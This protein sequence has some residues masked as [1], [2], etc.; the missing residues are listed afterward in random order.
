VLYNYNHQTQNK[1][2][3]MF[4]SVVLGVIAI[5]VFIV[6]FWVAIGYGVYSVVTDSEP[7]KVKVEKI[8]CGSPGCM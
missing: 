5:F 7:L 2:K 8:W 4:R 1:D 3:E 6:L